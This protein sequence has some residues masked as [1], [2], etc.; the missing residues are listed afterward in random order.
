MKYIATIVLM[1]YAGIASASAEEKPVKMTFSGTA[2]NSVINLQQP[3]SSMD[4]D[5]FAGDGTLGSFTVRN[6]RSLPNSP[7]PSSTCSGP[8]LL[9][10]TETV[11]GGVVRFHDGSL[12]YLNLTEGDDC[13]DLSIGEAHCVLTFQITGGT[14]RFKQAS[15]TLTMTETA[16]PVLSDAFSNP[17]FYAAT[18]EFTGTISGVSEEQ[19][20][21]EGQ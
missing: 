8:N 12:L 9:H 6:V 2:A 10:F 1:L 20:Q 3:N 18:G 5:N 17:V 4:E 7:T 11:G 19:R 16:L 21:D 13:I 15:G 14:G